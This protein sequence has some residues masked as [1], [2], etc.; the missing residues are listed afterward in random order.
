MGNSLMRDRQILNLET[1]RTGWIK[2]SEWMDIKNKL[3]FTKN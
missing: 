1:I 2:F 3:N